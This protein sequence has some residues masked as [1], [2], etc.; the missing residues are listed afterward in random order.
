MTGSHYWLTLC[1]KCVSNFDGLKLR[2]MNSESQPFE[3]KC[4]N[5]KLFVENDEFLHFFTSETS[6]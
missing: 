1:S 3:I 4:E 5:F 2:Q 6:N